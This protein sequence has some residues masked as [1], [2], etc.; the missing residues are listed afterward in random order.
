MNRV[1]LRVFGGLLIAA[2]CIAYAQQNGVQVERAWSRAT[3]P[4][5][6]GVIYLTITDT[7]VPPLPPRLRRRLHCTNRSART[8]FRRCARLRDWRCHLALR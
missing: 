6:T 1:L 8:A 2:P 4:G 3:I 5:Q 7:G